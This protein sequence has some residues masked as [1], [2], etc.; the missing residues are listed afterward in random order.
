MPLTADTCVETC[1]AVE[2]DVLPLTDALVRGI[3]SHS[4]CRWNRGC[5]AGLLVGLGDA[6][7]AGHPGAADAAVAGGVLREVLLVT[8]LCVEHQSTDLHCSL[9]GELSGVSSSGVS[10]RNLSF[11]PIARPSRSRLSGVGGGASRPARAPAS[12]I[13]CSSRSYA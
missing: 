8:A 9:S 13:R 2:C 3:S 6:D 10:E 12:L 7:G 1:A 4:T 5:S 11:T